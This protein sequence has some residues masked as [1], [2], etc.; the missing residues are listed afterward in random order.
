MRPGANERVFTS[1]RTIWF[2]NAGLATKQTC[3][4]HPLLGGVG[5]TATAIMVNGSLAIRLA[6]SAATDETGGEKDVIRYVIYRAN[7]PGPLGDP[8]VSVPA[9]NTSY[10][11]IDYDVAPFNTYYYSIAAQDCTPSL[12]GAVTIAPITL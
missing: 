2:A 10:S 1:T 12:S 11:Y 7:G 9:G 4:D 5:L 6:W 8:H 3:G